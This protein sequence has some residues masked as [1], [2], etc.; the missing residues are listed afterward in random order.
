MKNPS[1]KAKEK[2]EKELD[3][4]YEKYFAKTVTVL[5]EDLED[6]MSWAADGA[7]NATGDPA[8]ERIRKILNKNE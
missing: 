3:E 6:V 2:A 7:N 8:Y 1:N 4:F 5:K